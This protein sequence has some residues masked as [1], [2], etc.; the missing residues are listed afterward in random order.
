M[1][2]ASL[3]ESPNAAAGPKSGEVNKNFFEPN[4]FEVSTR[5]DI[6]PAPSTTND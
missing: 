3:T 1:S 4:D 6:E 5:L 2:G